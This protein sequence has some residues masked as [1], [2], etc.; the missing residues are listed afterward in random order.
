M[1]RSYLS[2]RF[3]LHYDGILDQK[4]DSIANIETYAIIND[5]HSD[6]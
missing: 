1:N 4:I 3:Q 5:W 2:D 6:L